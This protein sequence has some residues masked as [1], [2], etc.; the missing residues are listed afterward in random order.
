[1]QQPPATILCIDCGGTSHLLTYA[2]EDDR[3]EVGDILAYRCQDCNDRWDIV[4][5]D[6]D[7]EE[8]G[9]G[10]DIEQL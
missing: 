9:Q 6:E 1:M 8:I 7:L 4:L 10:D 3:W 5:E 2:R